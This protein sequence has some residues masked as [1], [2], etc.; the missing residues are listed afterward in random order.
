[1]ELCC[2]HLPSLFV[3]REP[4]VL[5]KIKPEGSGYGLFGNAGFAYGECRFYTG[6]IMT[7]RQAYTEVIYMP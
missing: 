7:S 4:T 5:Q 6:S 3:A 2:S 1:M